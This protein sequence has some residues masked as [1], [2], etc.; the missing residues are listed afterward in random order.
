MFHL[1]KLTADRLS[2]SLLTGLVMLAL[3]LPGCGDN[4]GSSDNN[5]VY[6]PDV[7]APG[8]AGECGS[9]RMTE[10]GSSDRRWCGFDRTSTILPDFVREGMTIAIAEPY[11]GSS[12][13][14]DPGE[15]CG[16]CWEI[17]TT[18]ATQIVMVHD[19]CPIEG[20]PI[21]AGGHFHFD[22]AGEVADRIDG[23]QWMGEAAVRRVPCPVSGNIHV[24]I[25]ARNQWGYMQIAFFNHRFPIRTVEY[26]A[27]DSEV[28]Q[29]MERCLA[30]WCLAEDMET[31]AQDG[32][33]GIFRLTS[34][35][36]E[37][38]EGSVAL[39]YSAA[40]GSDFDT[41]IQFAEADPPQGTC[42]FVVPGDVYDEQYGGIE[43][44]RWTANTWGTAAISE[45]SSNCADGSD[46]CLRLKSFV[47]SG[48]HLTYR[49]TFPTQTFSTLTLRLRTGSGTGTVSI[50]PRSE[51]AR[52]ANMT[53]VP[54]TGEWTTATIDVAASCPDTEWLHGLTIS[55]AS[56]AMDLYL[57][58]I[59]FD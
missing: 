29:P 21:C 34:A 5:S 36:G 45:T 46:S 25:S 2:R 12:Y 6:I 50:A 28:W 41:G 18:F 26:R 44:V 9:V 27:A 37:V 10:Y 32:P 39:P 52:C 49:H 42:D 11:N 3:L 35:A 17:S 22:I 30:R 38:I 51:D 23:G 53:E 7:P 59:V 1:L 40:Q 33:G 55:H 56:T 58:E 16:E 31:F 43:G 24:Y 48:V 8:V 13:G 15:A 54:V 57:D 14:G 20:N 19:L 47:D 4:N